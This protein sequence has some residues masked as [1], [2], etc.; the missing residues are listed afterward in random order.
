MNKKYLLFLLMTTVM[1][2]GCKTKQIASKQTL[3]KNP[4][5]EL[6]EKVQQAEPGFKTAN[7][8]KMSMALNIDGRAFT[9]SASCKIQRDSAMHMSVQPIPGFEMFKLEITPDSI[10]AFDKV[11][12][13]M[14]V[15]D[16]SYLEKRFGVAVDYYTLQ[17]II[18]NKFFTVGSQNPNKEKC[19]LSGESETL[20]GIQFENPTILQVMNVND[21]YRIDKVDL[22]SKS[23]NYLMSVLYSEFLLIDNVT[24]PQ[25]IKIQASNPK[26]SLNCDFNISKAMFDNKIVFSSI[27]SGRY[28][29]ADINQLLKK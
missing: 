23:T 24:F 2:A 3:Q 16:F 12:R 29:R 26:H 28:E 15:T 13:K 17:A 9:V 4:V 18:S 14:Y 1:F 21:V 10:R 22:T 20:R 8:S 7:V 19:K 5:A 6:I 25:K 11:N 27:E